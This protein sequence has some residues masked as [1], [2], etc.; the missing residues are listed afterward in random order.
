MM[1]VDDVALFPFKA[2]LKVFREIYNAAVQDLEQEGDRLRLELS[3]LYLGLESGAID[4]VT[5]DDRERAILDRLDEIEARDGTAADEERYLEEGA[6]G[7]EARDELDEEDP[8][9]DDDDDDDEDEDEDDDDDVVVESRGP[10]S[11]DDS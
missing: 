7:D 9:P 4:E 11:G 5:F 3:Q 10:L 1:L 6:V 2:I 8:G